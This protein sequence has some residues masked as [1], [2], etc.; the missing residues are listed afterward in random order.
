MDKLKKILF[1]LGTLLLLVGCS[2]NITQSDTDNNGPNPDT[3]TVDQ[4]TDGQNNGND[5]KKE[6]I[7]K[8]EEPSKNDGKPIDKEDK[9]DDPKVEE[10]LKIEDYFPPEKVIKYFRGEGNEYATEVETVFAKQGIY[11]PTIVNNGGTQILRIYKLNDNGIY[12]V[13]EQ[14]EYY[15]DMPPSMESLK[16]EFTEKEVLTGPLQKGHLI[17]GWKIID[18]EKNVTLPIGSFAHV[19]VLERSENSSVNRHYWSTE[20]GLVMKEFVYTDEDGFQTVV[21]SELERVDSL[22]N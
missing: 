6:P 15:E 4:D 5:G 9:E 17:N 16:K 2:I 22:A 10:K 19:I 1:V 14:P 12:V 7:D 21:T 8:E 13:Y 18:V 20:Y 3:N 11:L